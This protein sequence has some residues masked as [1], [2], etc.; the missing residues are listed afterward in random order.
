MKLKKTILC[1]LCATTLGLGSLQAN[2]QS[3]WN[4]LQF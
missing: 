3:V 4:K 1:A 2:A